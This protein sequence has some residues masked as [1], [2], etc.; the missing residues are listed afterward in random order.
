MLSTKEH[1]DV[2]REL[3]RKGDRLYLVPVPG[4]SSALPEQLAAI[5]KNISADLELVETYADVF[6]ALE[7]AV[8]GEKKRAIVLCGSLY[9]I[10][11]FLSSINN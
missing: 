4:H 10:G 1:A 8:E 9:L 3:L 5:A 2:F 7:V 6:A 11:H